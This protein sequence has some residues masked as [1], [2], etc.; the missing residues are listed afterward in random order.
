MIYE[1]NLA[2]Y[3]SALNFRECR[4]DMPLRIKEGTKNYEIICEN[5]KPGYD[6]EWQLSRTISNNIYNNR[7]TC[8]VEDLPNCSGST[9][10]VAFSRPNNSVS[11]AKISKVDRTSL[12]VA[13][14][15]CQE[16]KENNR[17]EVASCSIDIICK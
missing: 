13:S 4:P 15:T 10:L 5:F 14:F 7:G 6:V 8:L 16:F 3:F 9:G 12:G 1:F 11:L 2:S 17:G